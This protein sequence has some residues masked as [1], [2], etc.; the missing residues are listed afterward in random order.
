MARKNTKR[1]ARPK[2]V[3]RVGERIKPMRRK[4]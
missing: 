3:Q 1:S 2:T 4:R